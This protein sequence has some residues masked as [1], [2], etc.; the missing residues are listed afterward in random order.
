MSKQITELAIENQE[1]F[2]GKELRFEDNVTFDQCIKNP[3]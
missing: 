3:L 1:Y 2:R